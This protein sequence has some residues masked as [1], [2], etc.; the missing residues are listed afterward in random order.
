MNSEVESPGNYSSCSGTFLLK[1]KGGKRV[2]S[3]PF[4]S[5]KQVLVGTGISGPAI[6]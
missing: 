1:G 5:G 4:Y 6:H 3:G 2:E